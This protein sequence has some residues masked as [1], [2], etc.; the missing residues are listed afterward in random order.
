MTILQGHFAILLVVK[1]PDALSASDLE[2]ALEATAKRF[3]LVIAVKPL[4][5]PDN[6]EGEGDGEESESLT[7]SVHGADRPGIVK[8]VAGALADKGGNVVD[9]STQLIGAPERPVYVLTLRAVVPAGTSA[10]VEE[11]VTQ[12]ARELGVSCTVR[13]DDADLF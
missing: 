10:D 12:T 3:D 7:I 13:R 9:L 5:D 6:G 2:T 1:A 8:A 11:A 4:S